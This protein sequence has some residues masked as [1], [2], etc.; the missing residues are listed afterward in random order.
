MKL[1]TLTYSA[2]FPGITREDEITSVTDSTRK[3]K[4]GSLFVAVEGRNTDGHEKIKEAL[5]KGAAAVVTQRKTGTDGEIIVPDTRSAFSRLCSA[6]HSHPEREMKMIGITGTNG[7]TTVAQYLAHILN[8]S[9]TRCGVIGTLGAD[10]NG[11]N[12]DTGYTTP[13][14]D[15]LFSTLRAMADAGMKCCVMEVSSQALDQKR[16]DGIIFDTAVFTNIGR[17]HLDYHGRVDDYISAKSRLFRQCR[18][19]V[20][21]TDDVYAPEIAVR[22]Q[23]KDYVSCCIQCGCADFMAKDIHITENGTEFMFISAKS[24]SQIL[25]DS[26]CLF[27]VSDAVM[28]GA[29]AVTT[30]VDFYKAVEGMCTLPQIK[31][32]VQKISS[33][34]VDIYIDFAHTPE[35][36]GALL[37]SIGK[38]TGG[39]LI[40]VFGCGGDRDSRKRPSMGAVAENYS[41]TVII[42]DDNPRTE[43]PENITEDILSGI[44]RKNKIF[45]QHD[46]EKAIALAINKALPGDVVIIAGKGHEEYQIF[47]K[48]K[49]YFS[50]EKTVKKLLGI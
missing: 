25:I 15:I 22:A 29:A 36:L 19:A 50:D 48:E 28:A 42:T 26:P 17:D 30:G 27:S 21:N 1:S 43:D 8:N 44:K 16:T 32:R 18:K 41:D 9:G 13:D 6:L 23:L 38:I 5:L 40:T 10:Y 49:R 37:R 4:K 34:G 31:G 12:G 14:P 35:A 47:G 33:G 24:A 2:G 20:L 45:I 11:I 39:K 46:R 3:V 7:K